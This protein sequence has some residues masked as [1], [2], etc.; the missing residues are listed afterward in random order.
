M[1]KNIRKKKCNIDKIHKDIRNRFEPEPIQKVKTIKGIRK[2]CNI[3]KK[4]K[5]TRNHFE[6]EPVKK[7]AFRD[8]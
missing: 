6:A 4:L 3:D 5:N 7:L 2:K 8:I 1:I